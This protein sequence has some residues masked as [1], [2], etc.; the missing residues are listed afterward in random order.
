MKCLKM[1]TVSVGLVLLVAGQINSRQ[2][3]QSLGLASFPAAVLT[4]S[5]R[6]SPMG[7]HNGH[8]WRA[9][10]PPTM[11]HIVSKNGPLCALTWSTTWRNAETL[12]KT[13]KFLSPDT[14]PAY[15]S[16]ALLRS[17]QHRQQL[18]Y[19]K[20]AKR[21]VLLQPSRHFQGE[22]RIFH[23]GA[24]GNAYQQQKPPELL[25]LGR[26]EHQPWFAIKCY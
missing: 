6:F 24:F 22:A 10:W 21:S 3:I 8:Q 5:K 15:T 26:V 18:A 2:E 23:K 20:L 25:F 13:Q 12:M 17:P 1:V 4:L 9:Q 16:F 14:P 19:S 11:A 7:A